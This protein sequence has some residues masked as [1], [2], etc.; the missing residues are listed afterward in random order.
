MEDAKTCIDV[1]MQC[2]LDF[3][4]TLISA[5][6][7]RSGDS[8]PVNDD[9]FHKVCLCMMVFVDHGCHQLSRSLPILIN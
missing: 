4:N 1:I 9:V 6:L 2:T 5:N 3:R 7:D 8:V